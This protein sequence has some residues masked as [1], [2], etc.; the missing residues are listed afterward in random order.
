MSHLS[1]TLASARPGLA[2]ACLPY[3]LALAGVAVGLALLSWLPCLLRRCTHYQGTCRVLS[4][5][6]WA[7]RCE[8]AAVPTTMG[9][10]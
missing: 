1:A 2:E 5:S 4:R 7:R 6:T 9:Q 8:L 3:V 10:E